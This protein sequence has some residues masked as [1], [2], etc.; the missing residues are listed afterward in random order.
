MFSYWCIERLPINKGHIYCNLVTNIR[1]LVYTLIPPFPQLNLKLPSHF[2]W[3][4]YFLIKSAPLL[5]SNVIPG[6][7]TRR[8]WDWDGLDDDQHHVSLSRRPLPPL[9]H[10]HHLPVHHG[11]EVQ[12]SLPQSQLLQRREGDVVQQQ[13]GV[14]AVSWQILIGTHLALALVL[15]QVN[16][17]LALRNI[18]VV[19]N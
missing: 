6:L 5:R 16:T 15:T 11:Q 4:L 2:L 10:L 12:A 18:L 8:G 1:Q 19:I 9:H 3:L 17:I 7:Q 13:D 14:C